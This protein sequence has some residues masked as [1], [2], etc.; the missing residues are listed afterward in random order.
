M[1]IYLHVYLHIYIYIDRYLYIMIKVYICQTGCMHAGGVG[2]ADKGWSHQDAMHQCS[3][4]ALPGRGD[5]HIRGK[6]IVVQMAY[7]TT[8]SGMSLTSICSTRPA[9][10]LAHACTAMHSLIHGI[11]STLQETSFPLRVS[12]N[13]LYWPD[14]IYGHTPD[15]GGRKNGL[16]YW[17][18]LSCKSGTVVKSQ[19]PGVRS[20]QWVFS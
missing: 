20:S 4:T 3:G 5:N 6:Q 13:R 14:A 7:H 17:A 11:N 9:S 15:Q 8:N 2:Q 19:L 10:S 18:Y 12:R 16:V 1:Y